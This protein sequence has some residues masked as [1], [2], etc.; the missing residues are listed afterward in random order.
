CRARSD[1]A[2]TD[3]LNHA[4]R[5]VHV[6]DP[7]DSLF[8]IKDVSTLQDEGIRRTIHELL[9]AAQ[10]LDLLNGSETSLTFH[11]NSQI[12]I[13]EAPRRMTSM[14]SEAS[15]YDYL[16]LIDRPRITW[17]NGARVAFW[18]CPNIEFYEL[19]PPDG[20][21]RPI[22]QRPYPDVLNYSLRDYGNRSG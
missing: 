16:P 2:R 1:L 15:R 19:N 8:G 13:K 6:R 22:W 17:P 12:H 7:V 10:M 3:V 9:L 4:V 5:D 11:V 20:Q 18:V 21:G 14:Q